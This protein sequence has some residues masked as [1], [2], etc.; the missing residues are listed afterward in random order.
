MWAAR[1]T[2]PTVRKGDMLNNELSRNPLAVAN[3]ETIEPYIGWLSTWP[4]CRWLTVE[5]IA[6]AYARACAR[7]AARCISPTVRKGDTLNLEHV[8]HVGASAGLKR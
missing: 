5:H 6:L 3:V 2:S 1:C 7:A 8:G 4:W